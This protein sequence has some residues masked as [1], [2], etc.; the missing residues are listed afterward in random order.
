M[1][2]LK[3]LFIFALSI[4]LALILGLLTIHVQLQWL[5]PQW[6]IIVL[7]IWLCAYYIII[8]LPVVWLVGIIMDFSYDSLLGQHAL[9]LVLIAYFINKLHY[10]WVNY[11]TQQR[12]IIVL[13]IFILYTLVNHVLNNSWVIIFSPYTLLIML[14]PLISSLLWL[15]GYK[16]FVDDDNTLSLS[17]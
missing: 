8:P 6:V 2:Q 12:F 17:N 14:K 1:M 10:A 16:A 5:Y 4:I 9:M 13:S 15:W 7:L 3:L 11:T